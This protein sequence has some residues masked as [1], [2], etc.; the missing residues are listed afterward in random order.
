M[1]TSH[2]D[3]GLRSGGVI[4][5]FAADQNWVFVLVMSELVEIYH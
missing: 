3:F 4:A 1:V 5:T 2:A